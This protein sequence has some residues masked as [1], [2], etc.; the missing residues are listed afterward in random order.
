MMHGQLDVK[1]LKHNTKEYKILPLLRKGMR[2]VRIHLSLY[3]IYFI[4]R[5]VVWFK[6]TKR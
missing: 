3:S 1:I 6:Q 2:Y 5:V 4:D